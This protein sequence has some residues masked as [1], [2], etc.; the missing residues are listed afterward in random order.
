ML[1]TL[2]VPQH[3]VVGP[4]RR[5]LLTRRACRAPRRT[6]AAIVAEHADVLGR[7]CYRLGSSRGRRGARRAWLFSENES[8]AERL[9]ATKNT[10]RP[11]R[12]GR[13]SCRD[14]RERPRRRR[15]SR[16]RQARRPRLHPSP[17]VRSRRRREVRL[18]ACDP[19]PGRG[20][21][22]RST[23]FAT[24]STRC[25]S[26]AVAAPRPTS[27]YYADAIPGPASRPPSASSCAR[28]TPALLWLEAV[29]LLRDLQRR[30]SR[31]IRRATLPPPA[32]R[33]PSTAAQRRL[34]ARFYNRDVVSMPDKWEY[35]WFAAWDLAFHM[36]PFARVD[37][38]FAKERAG[39]A[40][41]ARVGTCTR[42]RADSGVRVGIRRRQPAG[43]R[44]PRMARLQDRPVDAQGQRD[45]VF[46]ARIFQKLLLNFTWWVNRKDAEGN[47]LFS[48]GFLGLDNIG[49]FDRSKP[50]PTGGR[51]EQADGTAWMAFYCSTMLSMALELASEDPAYE[52]VASKFFEHFVAISDAIE[53]ARRGTG[54]WDEQDGFYYDRC[55]ISPT[56]A[57][58]ARSCCGFARWS[59]SVSALRRA[60]CI[61]AVGGHRPASP[62]FK[63]AHAVVPRQPAP[64]SC[65]AHRWRH[66]P[67]TE[68][69]GG[70]QLHRL[71]AIPVARAPRAR[72]ADISCWTRSEF[73]VALRRCDLAVPR[74]RGRRKATYVSVSPSTAG[75]NLPR[76]L[77][78]RRVEHRRIVRRQFEPARAHPWIP[79]ELSCCVEALERY[80][81]FYGDELRVECPTGSGHL[82]AMPDEVARGARHDA[83]R[84]ICSWSRRQSAHRASTR[85]GE[86]R[87]T[88]TDPH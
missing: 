21:S 30:G 74:A 1:P 86:R 70:E 42:K 22:E 43:A 34:A 79:D 39:A 9:Y 2:W 72:A 68:Q 36:I 32:A 57:A 66:G 50:L 10:P 71:L 6:A 88:P 58:Q 35:P 83:S 53:L 82:D 84:E 25:S 17:R 78:A 75:S 47:H 81:H 41:D 33:L 7:L 37:P 20:R 15:E 46:L 80:H 60:R 76:R 64:T 59:G 19:L 85:R 54:L 13:L 16:R 27:A 31:A 51:L 48:G 69:Q 77:R 73:L 24:A 29:L 67:R 3:V 63:Q 18:R 28:P 45:R 14:R 8:N 4:R 38:Q 52:D 55:S 40:A 5:G 61:G 26:T 44:G 12:Q 62:A 23:P 11:V 49:V 65:T 87:A 56:T